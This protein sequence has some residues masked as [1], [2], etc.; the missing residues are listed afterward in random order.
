MFHKAQLLVSFPGGEWLHEKEAKRSRMSPPSDNDPTRA[1]LCEEGSVKLWSLSGKPIDLDG[2]LE[3]EFVVSDG[4]TNQAIFAVLVNDDDEGAAILF[5]NLFPKTEEMFNLDRAFLVVPITR[6]ARR[7]KA[8]ALA[9]TGKDAH[10]TYGASA[11]LSYLAR[12][13]WEARR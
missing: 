13:L 12:L 1:V 6:N 9:P 10:T 7:V 3:Y 5:D 11:K 8:W 4:K 2:E